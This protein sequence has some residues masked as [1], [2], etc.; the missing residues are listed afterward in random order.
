MRRGEEEKR[1]DRTIERRNEG[2]RGREGDWEMKRRKWEEV[3]R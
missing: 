1:D 3:M 2:A